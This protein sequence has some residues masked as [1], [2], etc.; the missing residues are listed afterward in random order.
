MFGHRLLHISSL[1]IIALLIAS[2]FLTAAIVTALN[3]SEVVIS[4]SGNIIA[5]PSHLG[6]P[7][8]DYYV[9]SLNSLYL[10]FN[11]SNTQYFLANENAA[12]IL[13]TVLG[14][15]RPGQKISINGSITLDADINIPV[16]AITMNW[17]NS[18]VT[19]TNN[20][21]LIS[22][23][24]HSNVKI[25]N[26][27]FYGTN[28]YTQV[29]YGVRSYYADSITVENCTFY[30]FG[31]Q[32]GVV[33]L[34]GGSGHT[35]E[36]NTFIGNWGNYAIVGNN[37]AYSTIADNT[38]DAL[39]A[40]TG[41]GVFGD[42]TASS[43]YNIVANNTISNIAPT[44]GHN[45]HFIYVSGSPNTKVYGNICQNS[46]GAS[47]VTFLIKSPN[48][49][50]YN[51]IVR[52]TVNHAF[53]IYPEPYYPD[54]TRVFNNTLIGINANSIYVFYL[55]GTANNITITDNTIINWFGVVR[56]QGKDA[57]HIYSNVL[58]A[59]NTISNSGYGIKIGDGGVNPYVTNVEIRNN[60]FT[61]MTAPT[62]YVEEYS[63]NVVIANNVITEYSAPVIQNYTS[64][65][66]IY[67]NIGLADYNP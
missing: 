41:I 17:C 16:D 32:Q 48:T 58:F 38:I 5:A 40:G 3:S 36:N 8:A 47:G 52:N 28:S 12:Y 57:S 22:V 29:S 27:V 44:G 18:T 4:S 26:G 46:S 64:S 60:V 23:G 25:I 56:L 1:C 67:D 61:G 6:L 33:Q 9:I 65:I 37:I 50:I 31:I 54:G 49:L 45:W 14:D 11:G 39:Y 10:A 55:V 63:N 20:G 53:H 59:D 24:G 19:K 62:F 43:R 2:L 35:V 21:R 51:N 15:M 7:S 66:S 34:N 13:N 30:N 42:N